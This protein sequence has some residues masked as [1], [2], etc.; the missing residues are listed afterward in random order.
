LLAEQT[1]KERSSFRKQGMNNNE[2]IFFVEHAYYHFLTLFNALL[3][4]ETREEE[5]RVEVGVEWAEIA[6]WLLIRRTRS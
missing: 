4:Y 5:E 3:F 6:G 1:I 2:M